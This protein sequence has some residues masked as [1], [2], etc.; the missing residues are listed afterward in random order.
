[1]LAGTLPS[2]RPAA[3]RCPTITAGAPAVMVGHLSAAGLTEG[4]V[5]ASMSPTALA[6]LRAKAGPDTVI[7]TDSLSMG[8]SSTSLHIDPAQA[9]ARALAAG[10]DWALV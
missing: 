8:A 3:E 10:A 6:Y 9:A 1:M 5:P 7:M 4:K 2:V